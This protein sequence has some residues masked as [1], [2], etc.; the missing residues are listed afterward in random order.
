MM[1]EQQI[2]QYFDQV[3]LVNSLKMQEM[4]A[5]RHSK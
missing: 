3:L 1:N 5:I 2:E 4:Q